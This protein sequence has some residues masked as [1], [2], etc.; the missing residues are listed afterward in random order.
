MSL[1]EFFQGVPIPIRMLRLW[2]G[3]PSSGGMFLLLAGRAAKPNGGS[4][5]WCAA[6][7][8][9]LCVCTTGRVSEAADNPPA[10]LGA[11]V[12]LLMAGNEPCKTRDLAG[13]YLAAR[14]VLQSVQGLEAQLAAQEGH[15][16]GLE[17]PLARREQALGA[18]QASALGRKRGAPHAA[19]L[20][21]QLAT[22]LDQCG[23]LSSGP[24]APRG[25]KGSP[26]RQCQQPVRARWSWIAED[27]SH[28]AHSS[29]VAS[30]PFLLLCLCSDKKCA[31]WSLLI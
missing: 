12:S 14:S 2:P 20:E 26:C 11:E 29:V 17:A 9:I 10:G 5:T 4:G 6:A 23:L 31:V 8:F 28:F 13:T 22:L 24:K 30:L 16:D 3:G 21:Q 7:R 25:D 1:E 27:W 19:S 18:A 15:L